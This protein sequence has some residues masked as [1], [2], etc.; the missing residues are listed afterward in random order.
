MGATTLGSAVNKVKDELE[1]EEKKIVKDMPK[2]Q[3]ESGLSLSLDETK[4][5]LAKL[6]QMQYSGVEIEFI[7]HLLQKLQNHLQ[8]LMTKD[9]Q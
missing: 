3:P 5:I 9:S 4:F 1:T 7:Y 6:A 8:Y 2:V